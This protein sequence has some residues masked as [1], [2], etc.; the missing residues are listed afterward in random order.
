MGRLRRPE[1]VIMTR[2]D[3]VPAASGGFGTRVWSGVFVHKGLTR[4]LCWSRLPGRPP[5][6]GGA[7]GCCTTLAQPSEV[8]CG[9]GVESVSCY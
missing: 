5:L 2:R 4:R 9:Q 8:P 7:R 3:P 1:V 6:G